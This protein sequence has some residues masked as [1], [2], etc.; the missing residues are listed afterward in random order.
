MEKASKRRVDDSDI[1][2]WTE[3]D[4]ARARPAR[5]VL[6]KLVEAAKRGRPKLANPKMMISFRI[7]TD[8]MERLKK[9]PE[10]RERAIKAFERTVRKGG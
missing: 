3:E 10:L 2:E 7:G 5:E 4:F 1:P 6:P 9:N 8:I